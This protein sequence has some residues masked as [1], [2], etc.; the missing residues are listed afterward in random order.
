MVH[1]YHHI[2]K[3][4]RSATK[5]QINE[6]EEKKT[7]TKSLAQKI[8]LSKRLKPRKAPPPKEDSQLPSNTRL[9][10]KEFQQQIDET[11][12]TVQRS[13]PEKHAREA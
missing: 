11:H 2:E 6:G 5:T 13:N 9:F 10:E 7:G 4:K 8:R 3:R 1:R 12:K